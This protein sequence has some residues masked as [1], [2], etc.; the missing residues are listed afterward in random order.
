MPSVEWNKQEWSAQLKAFE[1]SGLPYYG[2]QW[3]DP[4]P[5]AVFPPGVRWLVPEGVAAALLGARGR[6]RLLHR[7][8]RPK[9][10]FYPELWALI[11]EH[12]RPHVTPDSVVLEIG[13]GGGRWTRYLLDAKT[14]ILVDI[15]PD[16][17]DYLK[18]RFP[19]HAHKFVF[20]QPETHELRGV[21]DASIDYLLTFDAFVHVEPEGIREYLADIVRVLKPGA[22]AVIHYGDITKKAATEAG[23]HFAPMTATLM[24]EFLAQ[25]PALRVVLHDKAFLKHSN[26]VIV[27]RA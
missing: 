4:D 3:G 5:R 11:R 23:V 22:T 27:R 21:A 17:F 8:F 9:A 15:V 6:R 7:L 1:N 24:D 16:F 25:L 19:E 18:T 10:P 12:I 26:L 14:L 2:S 13:P 20:Y